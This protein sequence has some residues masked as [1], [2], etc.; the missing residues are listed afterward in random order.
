MLNHLY[1]TKERYAVELEREADNEIFKKML[2]KKSKSMMPS[3]AK[4]VDSPKSPGLGEANKKLTKTK[5]SD[6]LKKD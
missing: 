6:N 2:A 3:I 4:E 5:S 1:E